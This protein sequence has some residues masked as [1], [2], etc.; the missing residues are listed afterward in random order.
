MLP[1]RSKRMTVAQIKDRMDRRF[2]AVDQRFDVVDERFDTLE[3]R[4]R[5]LF[6]H[7][8]SLSQQ[9]APNKRTMDAA[10]EHQSTVLEEHDDRITDLGPPRV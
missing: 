10:F 4:F 2:K 5:R 3:A 7:L 1:A 6:I 9:V 8:E